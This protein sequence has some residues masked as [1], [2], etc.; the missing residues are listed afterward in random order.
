MS[1]ESEKHAEKKTLPPGISYRSWL[2]AYLKDPAEAA[3][4]DFQAGTEI[5]TQ[6]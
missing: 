6:V 4:R 5:K 1:R 2:V 3:G